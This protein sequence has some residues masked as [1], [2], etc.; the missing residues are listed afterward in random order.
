MT[1]DPTRHWKEKMVKL[2][3]PK[4][5]CVMKYRNGAYVCIN[6]G[7]EIETVEGK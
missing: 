3:C 1:E 5:K 6:C 2:R 4:C 7:Y